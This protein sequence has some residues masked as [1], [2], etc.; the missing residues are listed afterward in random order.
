MKALAGTA[1]KISGARRSPIPRSSI[2]EMRSSRYECAICGSD[3]HLYD[4]YMPGMM[5]GDVLGHECMGE[6]VEVGAGSNRT[7]GR[8]PRRYSVHHHLR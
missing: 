2:R 7:E 8:R 6:V 1:P 4:G 3:L 5:N